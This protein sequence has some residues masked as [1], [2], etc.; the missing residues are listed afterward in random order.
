MG[1]TMPKTIEELTQEMK[2]YYSSRELE[3][4]YAVSRATIWR[5]VQD[6]RL[7][8]PVRFGR[9]ARFVGAEVLEMEQ[10]AISRRDE[11]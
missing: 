11:I 4:R 7:P 9:S 8:Q 10:A 2:P 3:T 6:G 1:G 5:M